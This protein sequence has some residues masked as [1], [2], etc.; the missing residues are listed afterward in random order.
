MTI[1]TP[2][3]KKRS[4]HCF[5]LT[6]TSLARS[7]RLQKPLVEPLNTS[8]EKRDNLQYILTWVLS[9][10]NRK[11]LNLQMDRGKK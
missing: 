1:P 7:I 5:G 9:L 10:L 4:A 2:P 3:A 6:E 11:I 8:Y